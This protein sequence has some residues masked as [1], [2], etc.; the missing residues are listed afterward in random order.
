MTPHV[1]QYLCVCVGGSQIFKIKVQNLKLNSESR[2]IN[3]NSKIKAE[4]SEIKPKI[5]K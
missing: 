5:L 4:K 3:P 2:Q 1:G